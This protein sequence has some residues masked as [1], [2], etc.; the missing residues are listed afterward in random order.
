MKILIT[1]GAGYIGNIVVREFLKHSFIKKITI[2]DN[3]FFNQENSII[4]FLSDPKINFVKG[5]V[6]NKKLLKSHLK[7][8]DLIIPLAAIVGAPLSK[9]YKKLTKQLNFEQIK[10]I[11]DMKSK[12]QVI[13]LPVTNSGYGIGKKNKIYDEKSPLNPISLYGT[14]KVDAEKYL[15][16]N[17]NYISLRLATVFGVSPRMRV[18]LLVNNFVYRSQ[19]Y[20]KLVLFESHFVRNFIHIK[21]VAYAMIFLIKNY[22]KAK[23]NIYNVGLENANLT[24]KQL[25]LRIKKQI[26]ELKIFENNFKKDPDKRN[27][28]VSNRKIYSLGWRPKFSLDQGISELVEYFKLFKNQ[29]N[30]KNV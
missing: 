27:Y 16:N 18:D 20:K 23:N 10:N 12:H 11:C 29:K 13:L 4:D 7:N 28:I 9:I 17:L 24:K 14:T 8:H 15:L 2:I 6:R 3:F 30:N 25:A 21:D 1:G 5:D 19:K 22:N 26:T